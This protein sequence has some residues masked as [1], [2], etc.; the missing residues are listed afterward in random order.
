MQVQNDFL[1]KQ[2]GKTFHNDWFTSN[3]PTWLKAFDKL[4]WDT[5]KE[6]KVCEIGS[7]EGLSSLFILTYFPN[8]QLTCVDTWSGAQE[9]LIPDSF[10]N[11]ILSKTE[12]TFDQNLAD[13]KDRFTKVKTNSYDFFNSKNHLVN[14]DFDLIYIDGSHYADDIMIDA[15][16]SFQNLKP[17]GM[18][19]FDD[20]F[21]KHFERLTEN[22]AFAIN[23]FLNLKNNWLDIVCFDYQVIIQRKQFF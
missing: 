12:I 4:G 3:I 13:Y 1:I 22:P 11:S 19:I 6:L 17:G 10:E 8:A 18:L 5:E 7:W 20:Y 14:G 21:W 2:G 9:H 15:L 16:K 23:S